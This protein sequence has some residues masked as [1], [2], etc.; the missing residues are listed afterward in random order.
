[1]LA[2]LTVDPLQHKAKGKTKGAWGETIGYRVRV[3]MGEEGL[4]RDLGIGKFSTGVTLGR[5]RMVQ[6]MVSM[7]GLGGTWA[8]T[9]EKGPG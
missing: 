8:G 7:G 6:A 9:A 1:M 2:S 3:S 4:R 5:E